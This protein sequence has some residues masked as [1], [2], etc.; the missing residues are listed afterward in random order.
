MQYKKT[1]LVIIIILLILFLPVAIFATTIHIQNSKPIID[2]PNHDFLYN[3]KL[4]FYNNEELLGTYICKNTMHCDY[5][6]PQNVYEFNLDEHKEE[7]LEKLTLIHNRYVFLTDSV[8]PSSEDTEIVLFDLETNKEMGRYQEVKN[9]GVGIANDFYLAKNSNGLWGVLQFYDG[10][11]L[12]IPFMYDYI[13]LANQQNYETKQIVSNQFVVLK[14]NT[15]YLIDENNKKLTDSFID[16]IYT[17]NDQYVVTTNGSSMQLLTYSS[18]NRL[19]GDYKYI[20]FCSKYL[21]IV[22]N[23]NIFYM[24][25]LEN[26]KEVGNRH[27]VNNPN[28]LKLEV[29]KNRVIVRVNDEI[30]ENIAIS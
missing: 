12:K 1:T 23:N 27:N 30:I 6:T 2:N 19:F 24:F 5:A 13:A 21:A 20:N 8:S 11:N 28:T 7:Q 14:D 22:D 15:W 4:Y 3:G 17:Y 25:D 9:Y 26:N 29:M 10:V 18:R 16:R